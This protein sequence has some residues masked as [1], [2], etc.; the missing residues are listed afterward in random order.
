MIYILTAALLVGGV[1]AIWAIFLRKK[2]RSKKRHRYQKHG[3]DLPR[4]P[5][6]AQTGG[7]P[8]VRPTEQGN[9]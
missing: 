2:K 6:L 1:F 5:T 8:P 4:N 9:H 7:L 3:R